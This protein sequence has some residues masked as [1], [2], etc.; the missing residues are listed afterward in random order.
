MNKILLIVG[1]IFLSTS[2]FAQAV[3]D[4]ANRHPNGTRYNDMSS[5]I[6]GVLNGV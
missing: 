4:R 5:A 6:F 3:K 1:L 2:A